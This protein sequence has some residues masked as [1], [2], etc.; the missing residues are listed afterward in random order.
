MDGSRSGPAD[1]EVEEEEEGKYQQMITPPTSALLAAEELS[2]T[3]RYPDNGVWK[4]NQAD[5]AVALAVTAST[6]SLR[7]EE[8]CPGLRESSVNDN[9]SINHNESITPN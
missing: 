6:V 9:L 5:A 4:R 8:W 2:A 7:P 1:E 3:W